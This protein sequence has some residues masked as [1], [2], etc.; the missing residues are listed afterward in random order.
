MRR[1]L[2]YLMKSK[3]NP[4]GVP[5]A[6]IPII[7]LGRTTF[8]PQLAYSYVGRPLLILDSWLLPTPS[9]I[10][11][12]GRVTYLTGEYGRIHWAYL[13]YPL[14]GIYCLLRTYTLLCFFIL[15]VLRCLEGALG[16]C[17][18]VQHCL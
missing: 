3:G 16:K 14:L 17:C 11:P 7:M 15:C 2:V 9:L 13:A 10:P 18:G 4:V 5:S 1:I 6:V 8:F 12:W